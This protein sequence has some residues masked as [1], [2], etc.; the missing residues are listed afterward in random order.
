[1]SL[2]RP[3]TSEIPAQSAASGSQTE[4]PGLAEILSGKE[5]PAPDTPQAQQGVQAS[6]LPQ[7]SANEQVV[8][9]SEPDKSS[10]DS[11]TPPATEPPSPAVG[12]GNASLHQSVEPMLRAIVRRAIAEQMQTMNH[13]QRIGVMDRICWRL[14][15]LLTSR[16]Y[17]DIVFEKTHRYQVEEVFLLRHDSDTLISYAS[18]DPSRHSTP[19][20]IRYD[21]DRLVKELKNDEGEIETS[22]ELP[23]KRT[24]IVHSAENCYLIACVRG[25][26][27]AL[28]HS[29]LDYALMQVEQRFGKRL[30]DQG[31]HF[32]HV[33]QPLLEGCLLIQSPASPK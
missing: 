19:R 20:R 29:D 4:R 6:K 31:Q 15:A 23:N 3:I 7:L 14:R 33:L 16:T 11:V 27:N 28:V 1:M 21:L 22:A 18:S 2:A 5:L 25:R 9:R 30:R 26:A 8:E 10:D 17:D 32:I 13:F 24:A 12:L